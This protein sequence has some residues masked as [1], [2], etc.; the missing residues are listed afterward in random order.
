MAE[1]LKKAL[2]HIAF[3]TR[4][5]FCKRRCTVCARRCAEPSRPR[6]LK[7]AFILGAFSSR[8]RVSRPRRR[9]PESDAFPYARA[10]ALWD[11]S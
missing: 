2:Y 8:A 5:D 9:G 3:S 4:R 11:K 1:Q 6:E 7:K 10:A